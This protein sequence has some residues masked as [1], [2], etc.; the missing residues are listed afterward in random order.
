M[1]EIAEKTT[2]REEVTIFTW[3]FQLINLN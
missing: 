1:F 3:N 2:N